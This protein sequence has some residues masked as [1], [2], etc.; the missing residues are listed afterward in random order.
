[1][2]SAGSCFDSRRRIAICV[3]SM[4]PSATAA[5]TLRAESST[6]CGGLGCVILRHG[7]GLL[8]AG[9]APCGSQLFGAQDGTT[10]WR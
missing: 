3:R 6:V 4:S 1:M 9:L 2:V 8:G 5:I 10:P 7:D